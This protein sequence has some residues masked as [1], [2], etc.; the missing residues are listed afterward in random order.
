MES[1]RSYILRVRDE[2]GEDRYIPVNDFTIQQYSCGL[3]AGTAV[4]LKHDIPILDSE[5]NTTGRVHQRGEIWQVLTGADADPSAVWFRQADG[6]L[7]S[8][9]DDPSIF[10]TFE[11]LGD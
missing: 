9:E 4:R 11:V 7:H 6:Q 8:W 2:S 5:G 1:D 3:R 10:E